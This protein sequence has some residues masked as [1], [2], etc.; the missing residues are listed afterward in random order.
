M[1]AAWVWFYGSAVCWAQGARG[2]MDSGPKS[3]VPSYLIIIFA[4]GLGLLIVCRTGKRTTTFR[5]VE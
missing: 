2:P 3:Y 1:T 4:V 5:R